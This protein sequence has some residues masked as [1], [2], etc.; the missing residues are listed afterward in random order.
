MSEVVTVHEKSGWVAKVFSKQN[1]AAIIPFAAA[2]IFK[3]F[4]VEIPS[5]I[6]EDMIP[7]AS[8]GVV[9]LAIVCAW[10][11]K[12]LYYTLKPARK[13][14]LKSVDN[15]EDENIPTIRCENDTNL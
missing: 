6:P 10:A 1:I 14:R 4:G 7:T 12:K 2:L 11:I 9:A 8:T 15:D 3:G 13:L 5:W